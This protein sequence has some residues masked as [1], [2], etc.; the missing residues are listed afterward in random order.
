MTKTGIPRGP[1]LRA[2]ASPGWSPP[3]TRAPTFSFAWA[4]GIRDGIALL[5]C[6]IVYKLAR[7]LT[8]KRSV[9]TKVGRQLVRGEFGAGYKVEQ[10]TKGAGS[11]RP[12]EV[13][14]GNRAG[15]PGFQDGVSVLEVQAADQLGRQKFVA[16]DIHGV[17]RTQQ[18][19]VDH[20]AASVVQLQ[21]HIGP[22]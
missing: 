6:S 1:R 13:K 16:S 11:R 22:D 4:G 3:I 18:D 10:R 21:L 14:P 15:K 20:A 17:P 19:V 9:A 8:I 2:M 7:R 12:D 5:G